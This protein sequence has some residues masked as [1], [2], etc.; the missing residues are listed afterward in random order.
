MRQAQD[1]DFIDL[2]IK[3]GKLPLSRNEIESLI[4]EPLSFAGNAVLQCQAVLAKITF[5][6]AKWPQPSSYKAGQIL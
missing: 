5:L 1:V 3:D 6:L 2:L 4:F